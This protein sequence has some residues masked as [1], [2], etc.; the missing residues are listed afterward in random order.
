[1][2]FD[3][4]DVEIASSASPFAVGGARIDLRSPVSTEVRPLKDVADFADLNDCAGEVA[5]TAGAGFSGV[6]GRLALK[7]NANA[8]PSWSEPSLFGSRLGLDE[9]AGEAAVLFKYARGGEVS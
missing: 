8:A 6:V 9:G 7:S 1:M 3:L 5:C 4:E 2:L